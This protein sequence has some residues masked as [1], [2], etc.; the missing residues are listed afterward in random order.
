MVNRVATLNLSEPKAGETMVLP[1]VLS[2]LD[3]ANI[4]HQDEMYEI[5]KNDCKARADEGAK[6][7]GTY[8]MT[9]NGRG[10]YLGPFADLYQEAL[11]GIFYSTQ[12]VLSYKAGSDELRAM[13]FAR[14]MFIA[15]AYVLR[16]QIGKMEE[17]QSEK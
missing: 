17:K 4:E 8:L 3:N 2:Y 9:N 5:I 12:G 1:F 13:E 6:K 14:E 15:A 10:G 7:Y 11:D 16:E